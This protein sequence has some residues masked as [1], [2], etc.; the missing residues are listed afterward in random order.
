MIRLGSYAVATNAGSILG[1][2]SV[3]ADELATRVFR[4]LSALEEED[5]A[6]RRALSLELQRHT[7][8][9]QAFAH[10][11]VSAHDS[12]FSRVA[13]EEALSLYRRHGLSARTGVQTLYQNTSGF[14]CKYFS[15]SGNQKSF[16][17]LCF[18][19][20]GM[21]DRVEGLIERRVGDKRGAEEADLDEGE[22]EEPRRRQKK[23]D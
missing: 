8:V 14:W 16:S 17:N 23:H 21:I 3:L 18:L 13:R 22:D 6:R 2:V 4:L 19:A 11:S 5:V 15:T 9:V 10:R 12:L 7:N 1:P 20:E